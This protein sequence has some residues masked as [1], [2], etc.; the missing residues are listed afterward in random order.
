MTAFDRALDFVLAREGGYSADP[1][2]PGGE[3][4][5]GISKRAYPA[6]DIAALTRAGAAEIYQR[7]Y[8]A[9]LFCAD[10]AYPLALAL[11]DTA[12]NCGVKTAIRLGQKAA[13]LEIDGV[14]GPKTRAAW[15]ASPRLIAEAL[16]AERCVHYASLDTC[17][18][19]G[20]GWFRR[21][22]TCALEGAS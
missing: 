15:Q 6:V 7:D 5:F 9:P 13:G 12:V 19:F 20:R 16:L 14:V 21:V 2:D 11:F 17:A 3:T 22:L 4:N 8:W 1:H 18:R 10:Y